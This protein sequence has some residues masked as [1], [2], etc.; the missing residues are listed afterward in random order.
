MLTFASFITIPIDAFRILSTLLSIPSVSKNG[1]TISIVWR[2]SDTPVRETS[3]SLTVNE[4][5][6]R[7]NLSPE[8]RTV[9]FMSS[10]ARNAAD[11]NF[12]K[13]FATL[14]YQNLERKNKHKEKEKIEDFTK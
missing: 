4:V 3:E 12:L 14:E 8:F 2:A 6:A 10:M 9:S 13:C 11:H 7:H 5:K 1:R